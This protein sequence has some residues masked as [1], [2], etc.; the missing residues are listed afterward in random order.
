MAR[1]LYCRNKFLSVAAI[2][3]AAILI[4]GIMNTGCARLGCQ[5]EKPQ[6]VPSPSPTIVENKPVPADDSM[7]LTDIG[8]VNK[9]LDRGNID[10]AKAWQVLEPLLQQ[11]PNDPGL[12]FTKSRLLWTE[13]KYAEAQTTVN[14]VLEKDPKNAS[15]LAFKASV[16]LDNFQNKEA[17][18]Y[19][20]R[21]KEIDP[22]SQKSQLL[23]AQVLVNTMEYAQAES[24]LNALIKKYPD[25]IEAYKILANAYD[26]SLQTDKGIEFLNAAVKRNWSNPKDKSF[27]LGRMGEMYERKGNMQ[28]AVKAMDE[29]VKLDP[30]NALASGKLAMFT[31]VLENPGQMRKDVVKAAGEKNADSPY[32]LYAQAQLAMYDGQFGPARVFINE[33]IKRFPLNITGYFLLGKF[34]LDNYE[35]KI[36]QRAY[37]QA[38]VR[39]PG[40]YDTKMGEIFLALIQRDFD[41]ANKM[42]SDFVILEHRKA[43]YYRRLGDVYYKHL[44]EPA[45]AREYY[46][47]AAGITGQGLESV[48]ASVALGKI[49][50]GEGKVTEAEKYFNLALAK[51]PAMYSVYADIIDCAIGN[52][53]FDLAKKYMGLWDQESAK[54]KSPP[55]AVSSAYI[56]FAYMYSIVGEVEEA[57][58]LIELAKRAEPGNPLLEVSLGRIAMME[59]N[60]EA[61]KGYFGTSVKNDK[62]DAFSWVWLGVI[63]EQEGK[64]KE[65]ET[66]F[67][68]AK[69]VFSTVGPPK[70]MEQLAPSMVDYLK[71]CDYA[72]IKDR[73]NAVLNLKKAIEE[74]AFNAPRAYADPEFYS[75]RVDPFFKNELPQI[76]KTVKDRTPP[77]TKDELTWEYERQGQ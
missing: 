31:V 76:L 51:S 10:S 67:D 9:A 29:A 2:I 15:A 23:Q 30:D 43:E 58:R 24:M 62:H 75:M 70:F 35:Y 52:K 26:Q 27:L 47:K 41:K 68:N 65:A 20:K 3:I 59:G 13:G 34:S 42:M 72:F 57:K 55:R 33:A 71:A 64:Q 73:K 44:R 36:A 56:R 12:L 25:S 77:P 50:L 63:A 7:T 46:N 45:K 5:R 21:L 6:A 49:E 28:E 32:P 18:E 74:D 19:V 16:L 53:K 14:Q 11:N 66:C 22:G 17:A 38:E 69:K 8:S 4:L 48:M 61:A 40:D 60:K 1:H 54:L 39:R 37:A